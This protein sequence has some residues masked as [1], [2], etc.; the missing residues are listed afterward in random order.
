M[1]MKLGHGGERPKQTAATKRPHRRHGPADAL[2]VWK[3]RI[4][5]PFLVSNLPESAAL[6]GLRRRSLWTFVAGGAV[7]CFTLYQL[8]EY[9][10]GK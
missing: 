2:V 10:L 5:R 3:G 9:L 7:L 4:G 6:A 8:I 1:M